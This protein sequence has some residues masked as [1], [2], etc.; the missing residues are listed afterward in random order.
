LIREYNRLAREFRF[1]TVDARKSIDQIQGDLRRHISA[2]LERSKS[3]TSSGE[4]AAPT[5]IRR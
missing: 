5:A 1:T 3:A 4:I 2:Y